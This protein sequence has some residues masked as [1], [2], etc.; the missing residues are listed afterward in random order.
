MV[1]IFGNLYRILN[2]KNCSTFDS[3]C[4][5]N[6][7]QNSMQFNRHKSDYQSLIRMEF[8][9]QNLSEK[10]QNLQSENRQL[11]QKLLEL[12]VQINT[13]S[14][15]SNDLGVPQWK[16]QENR[17]TRKLS[18]SKI[19]SYKFVQ[20]ESTILQGGAI[21]SAALEPKGENIAVASLSGSITILTSSLRPNATLPSQS[22]ACR[23]VFWTSSG[24]V[25]CGFDKKIKFWDLNKLTSQDIDANGLAHS[26]GGLQDDPNSV[27][28]AA[29]DTVFWIDRR[30]QTP[31]T[32]S[33]G[34][35]ATAVTCYKDYLLYGGYDGYVS[36]VDKRSLNTG[37]IA[38]LNIEG[39][40][41]SSLSHVLEKSGNCIV[42]S[43]YKSPKM[44]NFGDKIELK[45]LHVDA[46][47]RFGCRSD[48]TDNSLIFDGDLA[49]I[50]GGKI[51]S[52]WDGVPDSEP[53]LLDDVGGFI[54]GGI[55][56]TNLSQKLLTYSEDGIISIW[57]LRQM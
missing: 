46:P 37:N 50:C 55:F 28:V 57:S 52:F 42:T 20:S 2:K 29:G 30:R 10:N 53:Q 33:A 41:I 19:R 1:L 43:S 18:R 13:L 44:L 25:S 3:K 11:R 5:M 15:I 12:Y 39:G 48:I 38:H 54:Y 56:M 32:I 45:E 9:S 4:F 22:F 17:K 6:E 31:I 24:L 27:F 7:A 51:A 40:P 14:S 35:Q 26:I 23:D 34:T 36:I 8:P 47:D 16:E 49:T 21:Y